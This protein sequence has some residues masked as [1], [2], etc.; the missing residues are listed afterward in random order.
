MGGGES[1]RPRVPRHFVADLADPAQLRDT[2]HEARRMG[3][4]P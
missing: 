3:S 4:A 1:H 2:N